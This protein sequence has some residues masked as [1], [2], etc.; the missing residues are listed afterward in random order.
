MSVVEFEE[1]LRQTLSDRRIS[2]SERR[3]LR[4]RLAQEQLGDEGLKQ[5]RHKAFMLARELE[6]S[7][8]M[9]WLEDVVKLLMPEEPEVVKSDAYFSPEDDCA[10]VIAGLIGQATRKIEVCVFTL[11]DDR[12]SDALIAANDRGARVRIITDVDKS[13]DRGSDVA[14]FR[15]AGIDVVVD[16]GEKHMH[17]KFA[18]F[19]G[20]LLLTGSYNWTRSAS[21]Y[22][23]ENILITDDARLIQSF[24]REFEKLF[25]RFW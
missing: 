22:N 20:E 25:V 3:A 13:F 9:L 1:I 2:R 15:R 11:T 18:I 21:Y 16:E 10:E 8:I 7:E 19:D 12:L 6:D 23:Q 24:E 17:H 4:L 5:L 14:R